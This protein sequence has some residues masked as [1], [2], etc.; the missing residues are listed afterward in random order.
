MKA[1]LAPIVAALAGLMAAGQ[2][3][4]SPGSVLPV[5]TPYNAPI[6]SSFVTNCPDG[7]TGGGCTPANANFPMTTGTSG[8]VGSPLSQEFDVSMP[9]DLTSLVL[10]LSDNT[11]ADGG[12]MLVYLVPDPTG[13][14]CRRTT[15]ASN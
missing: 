4:A 9:M 15:A 3:H 7:L 6:Y 12:S 2:A 13:A 11:P 14:I 5:S 8:V 1:L 10:R